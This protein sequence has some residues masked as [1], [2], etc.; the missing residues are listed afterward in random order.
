[1]LPEPRPPVI[2]R[3]PVFFVAARR[4]STSG[5]ANVSRVPC[6]ATVTSGDE[7]A[8]VP[9]GRSA[10]GL[11]W[12]L[13]WPERAIWPALRG[14]TVPEGRHRRGAHGLHRGLLAGPEPEG[15]GR[16]V[17]EHPEPVDPLGPPGADGGQ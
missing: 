2:R 16:L 9:I 10:R 1:M 15:V 6:R 8:V 13:G 5:R 12:I 14:G 3:R 11:Q 7:W 4:R 17:D